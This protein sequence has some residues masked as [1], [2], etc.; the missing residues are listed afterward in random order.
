MFKLRSQIDKRNGKNSTEHTYFK[1]IET[2][3][4]T[5]IFTYKTL[6]HIQKLC[7]VLLT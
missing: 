6:R 1:N 7:Y 5:F 3:L 4:T 2:T